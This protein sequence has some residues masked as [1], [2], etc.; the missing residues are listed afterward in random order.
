M[1]KH[2]HVLLAQLE[3]RLKQQQGGATGN[4][5]VVAESPVVLSKMN[6]Y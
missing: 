5:E 3:E 6:E 4:A 1:K 2:P